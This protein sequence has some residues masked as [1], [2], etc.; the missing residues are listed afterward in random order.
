MFVLYAAESSLGVSS[1][2]KLWFIGIPF[3]YHERRGYLSFDDNHKQTLSK[4]NLLT[5]GAM[6]GKRF[7]LLK[8][9]RMH[10]AA[11]V[12]YGSTIDDTLP[13]IQI[14]DTTIMPTQMMSI[15]FHGNLIADVQY[16]MKVS[17]DAS[18]YWHAGYGVHYAELSEYE[19]LNNNPK[20]KV[21]DE[22]L[23]TNTMWSGSVH[24]GVGFEIAMTPIFGFAASYTLRYWHP[25]H[26]GMVRDLFPYKP[27]DYRERFFSHEFDLIILVK[28]Y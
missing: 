1:L 4:G 25:V 6:L 14:N 8:G 24:G 16:P 26:Y 5:G 9:F 7:L 19:T 12:H 11:S 13:A 10:V 17:T 21:N 28:R 23:E 18:W 2:N 3:Q 15:F 27:I 20:I 22:Y